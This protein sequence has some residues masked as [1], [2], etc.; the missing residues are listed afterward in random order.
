MQLLIGADPELFV[1]D[2]TNGS[3]ISA[4][5][6]IPGSKQEPFRV[7]NGAIQPDGTALEFNI[8]PVSDADSFVSSINSLMKVLTDEVKQKNTNFSLSINPVASFELA[9]L[10]SLP[11]VA[12]ELG[13]SPDFDAYRM[14]ENETPCS[15]VNFRTAAGH[16]H[17]GWTQDADYLSPE[18]FALCQALTKQHDIALFIPSLLFDPD[19]TRRNLYGR[20]G[21]FRPKPYGLEYRVLSNQW[22][23]SEH[24]MR[25]V[26]NCTL[27]ATQ[28]LAE[29]F[30]YYRFVR[31]KQVN[32]L[33]SMVRQKAREKAIRRLADQYRFIQLP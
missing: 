25:W 17:I 3:F 29:G 13:C 27:R 33:A 1:Q 31:P 28:E 8:E 19:N 20:P 12:T 5:D 22:L 26:F 32:T 30:E 21:A 23:T 14:C 6:L 15:S 24:L 7:P 4:H 16:I 10:D 9:Y 18:H 2:S 11:P